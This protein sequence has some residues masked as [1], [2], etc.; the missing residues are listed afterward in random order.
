MIALKIDHINI[1]VENPQVVSDFFIS[2]FGFSKTLD[3]NLSGKWIDN[4][5]GF[6]N[7]N[8]DCMLLELPN[9]SCKIEL[10]KFHSPIMEVQQINML[11]M[12]GIRH[13]AVEV[14]DI[15]EVRDKAKA[16]GYDFFSP[17]T[18]VPREINPKGKTL[19]YIKGPEGIIIEVA[20]F[21]KT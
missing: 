19:F 11:N 6:S 7:V 1:V 15:T 12:Q 20:E 10:S 13:F 3:T 9:G 14:K 17:P 16:L 8:T 18:E 4:I 21:G 5:M 2:C